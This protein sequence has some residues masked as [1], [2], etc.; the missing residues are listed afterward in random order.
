[1][2]KSTWK[3]LH[4][5]RN[6]AFT[7]IE[8][9]ISMVL[10]AIGLLALLPLQIQAVQNGATG[11]RYS[12]AGVV[13]R[14]TMEVLERIPWAQLTAAAWTAP[15]W[16]AEAGFAVGDVPVR[17]DKADGGTNTYEVYQVRYRVTPDPG[18]IY[19]R[20]VDVQVSWSEKNFPNRSITLSSIRYNQ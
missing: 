5:Q 7:L 1:M 17:V 16:I 2:V 6:N 20:M 9:S 11:W 8:V 10:L 3:S 13:A 14:D 4:G 15:A 19:L 12:Q 18:N